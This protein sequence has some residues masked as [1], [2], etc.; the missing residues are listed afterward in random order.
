MAQRF[1]EKVQP[2]AGQESSRNGLEIGARWKMY[3]VEVVSL[4]VSALKICT[5]ETSNDTTSNE[6]LLFRLGMGFIVT[7]RWCH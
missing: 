2:V 7:N 3:L 6:I 1:N 5:E 4:E